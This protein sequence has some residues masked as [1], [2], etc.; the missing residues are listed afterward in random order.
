MN[1]VSFSHVEGDF[2]YIPSAGMS[3]SRTGNRRLP[4]WEYVAQSHFLRSFGAQASKLGVP[5]TFHFSLFTSH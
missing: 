3:S 1:I 5:L 2:A 4:P